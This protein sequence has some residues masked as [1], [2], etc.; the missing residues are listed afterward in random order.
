MSGETKSDKISTTLKSIFGAGLLVI[1]GGLVSKIWDALPPWAV[2]L[3]VTLGTMFVCVFPVWRIGT[4]HVDRG[5][6]RA[7][8]AVRTPAQP[9]AAEL[10]V[11]QDTDMLNWLM[12]AIIVATIIGLLL[13]TWICNLLDVPSPTD[14]LRWAFD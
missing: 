14:L 13:A 3:L 11:R 9:E 6:A 4:A 1:T 7:R 10:P 8:N 12:A 5:I 2:A